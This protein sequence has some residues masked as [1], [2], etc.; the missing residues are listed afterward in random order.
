VL[1]GYNPDL[2]GAVKR[3][4][5]GAVIA[6]VPAAVQRLQAIGFE[7]RFTAA[8]WTYLVRPGN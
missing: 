3:L 2:V 7:P 6:H 8:D 5:I 4:Q 1:R